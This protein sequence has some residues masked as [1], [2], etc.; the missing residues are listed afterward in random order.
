MILIITEHSLWDQD[1]GVLQAGE[2]ENKHYKKGYNSY[3]NPFRD[4]PYKSISL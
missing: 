4:I 2:E 3:Q 1:L